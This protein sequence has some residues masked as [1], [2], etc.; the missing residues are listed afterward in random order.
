VAFFVLRDATGPVVLINSAGAS[1]HDPAPLFGEPSFSAEVL[2]ASNEL[3]AQVA[4][5]RG[6]HGAARF[7]FR[8]GAGLEGALLVLTPV[9]ATPWLPAL[10]VLGEATAGLVHMWDADRRLR[11]LAERHRLVAQATQHVI[12]DWDLST[13]TLSWNARMADVFGHAADP[14][15]ERIAWLRGLLHPEDR[16]RAKL[17]LEKAMNERELFWTCEYRFRRA[18]STYAWVF[19]RGAI[20]YD[21]EA[22]ATRMLGVMEDISRDRELESRLAL[23]SRLAAVGSLASG[24]AHEINNPLAWVTSNLGFALEELKKLGREGD[25]AEACD[26]I[27]EALDDSQTGANRIAQIVSDLRTF[28]HADSDHLSPVSVRRVV[29]GALT[30]AN[31]ELRHRARVVR[32]LDDAPMVM[33]NEARLGHAVLNLVLN[34]AWS[35]GSPKG[36]AEVRIS[37]SKGSRGYALI[38][39][40][41]NGPPLSPE[42]LPHV[43]DPFY[44]ARPGGEGLGLGLAVTHSIVVGFGGSIDVESDELGTVFRVLLPGVSDDQ[45]PTQRAAEPPTVKDRRPVLMVI[46]DEPSILSAIMRTLTPTYE[47]LGFTDGRHALA[48]L[49]SREPDLILCDVMMPDLSGAQVW[50]RIEADWPLLLPRVVLLTGGAFTVE[51]QAFVERC[52]AP[53]V[54]KPFSPTTLRDT[55]ARML[56]MTTEA[57]ESS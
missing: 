16:E 42:V 20:V 49:K 56:G 8:G 9:E 51:A 47:V 26:E 40:A 18:D 43:F 38:E 3:I 33:A 41:D 57:V 55:V 19:D 4:T 31:N 13:D 52:P 1:L 45:V 34:A 46:D 53:V 25:N 5:P 44:S 54:D 32:T 12:Y 21:G 10:K 6:L 17:S 28:A 27:A 2:P 7:M 11:D 22:R 15:H 14:A 23:S 24:I 48:S 35:A 37:T 29:E 50:A 36:S 39:V 30:M